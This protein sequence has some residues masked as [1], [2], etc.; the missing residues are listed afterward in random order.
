MGPL[1]SLCCP[2]GP[3]LPPSGPPGT[4][5]PGAPPPGPLLLLAVVGTV[6]LPG[7][8]GF[9]AVVPWEGAGIGVRLEAS[10]ALV[11]LLSSGRPGP[12]LFPDVVGV[13]GRP[14]ESVS[15][16]EGRVLGA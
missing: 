3:L 2:P 9:A 8:A 1:F 15:D 12:L 10:V 11:G 5:E 4:W 6:G 14:W 13:T 7:F 16:I